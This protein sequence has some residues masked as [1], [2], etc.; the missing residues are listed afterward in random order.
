MIM[1]HGMK[2][3]KGKGFY[4][5]DKIVTR[6]LY[7]CGWPLLPNHRENEIRRLRRDLSVNSFPPFLC[8]KMQ[9]PQL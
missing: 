8:G 9:S 6:N 4:L 2:V 3:K 1:V 7:L 5:K